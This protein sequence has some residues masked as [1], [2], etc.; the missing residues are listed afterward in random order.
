MQ[1]PDQDL[2]KTHPVLKEVNKILI[3]KIDDKTH[4]NGSS[5]FKKLK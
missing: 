4:Q 3:H 2:L 1:I 5:Y